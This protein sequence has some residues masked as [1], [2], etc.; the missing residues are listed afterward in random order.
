[1]NGVENAARVEY[2]ATGSLAAYRSL[3]NHAGVD[4]ETVVRHA[5]NG[6]LR[7]LIDSRVAERKIEAGHL[8]RIK[9]LADLR[10]R[11][12]LLGG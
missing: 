2:A 11:G 9:R 1:V 8:E 5:R 3:A 6:T 4:L 7:S 10:V 12:I